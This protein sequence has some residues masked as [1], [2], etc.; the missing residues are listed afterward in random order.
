MILWTADETNTHFL[1]T[2]L[3][4]YNS[5]YFLDAAEF[6][7]NMLIL[8][9]FQLS[10][11]QNSASNVLDLLFVNNH[12]DVR[13]SEDRSKIIEHSH[14]D[15][16]HKPYEIFEYSER[17][18]ASSHE[19]ISIFSFKRGNYQRMCRQLDNINFTY[20]INR[21]DLMCVWIFLW[22]YGSVNNQQCTKDQNNNK[23]K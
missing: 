20:E 2:G 17:S 5:Q 6:L 21:L 10:N 15:V 3:A 4:T 11:I 13:M 9:L 8:P 19:E 12:R 23:Y 1:P 14:Q 18:I 16:F 7:N 22:C